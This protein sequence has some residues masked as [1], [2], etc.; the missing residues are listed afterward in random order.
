MERERWMS[1]PGFEI[2][3]IAL[4]IKNLIT[5][6]STEISP[7]KL[8]RTLWTCTE[9]RRRSTQRCQGWQ[10]STCVCL[11]PAHTGQEGVLVDGVAPE[12]K[13]AEHVRG[14]CVHA[15]FRER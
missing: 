1:S 11:V 15:T 8:T 12:Q 6:I 14:D 9:P 10:G 3:T 5:A 4:Q 2:L 7:W 13:E